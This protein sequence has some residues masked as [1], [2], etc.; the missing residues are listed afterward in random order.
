MVET[1]STLL[2]RRLSGLKSN[3]KCASNGNPRNCEA[4]Q[5]ENCASVAREKAIDRSKLWISDGVASP[6]GFKIINRAGSSVC[7]SRML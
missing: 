1:D 7:S 5:N 3:L 6:G 2:L 4:G